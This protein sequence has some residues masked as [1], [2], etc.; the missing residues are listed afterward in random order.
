M[1]ETTYVLKV[2]RFYLNP[3]APFLTPLFGQRHATLTRASGA[4]NEFCTALTWRM[5]AISRSGV[6]L[7]LTLRKKRKDPNPVISL[8]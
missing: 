2:N 7:A 6:F 3:T 5:A 8:T 1:C 4:D